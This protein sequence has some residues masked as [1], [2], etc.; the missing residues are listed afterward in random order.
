MKITKRNQLI[1]IVIMGLLILFSAYS[2]DNNGI[3]EPQDEINSISQPVGIPND[4]FQRI[5]WNAEAKSQMNQL[6]RGSHSHMIVANNGGSV[7]GSVTFDNTVE[8]PAEALGENTMVT[9][10]VIVVENHNQDGAEVDFLPS[11]EFLS[12]VVV[13]LSWSYLELADDEEFEAFYSQDDGETWFEVNAL[14]VNFE[15]ETLS[16][17]IDHFTRFAWGK[18]IIVNE[19]D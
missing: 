7:G 18:R 13:T 4:Q 15:D 19:E 10:E 3:M 14:E 17:Q 5:G 16:F 1:Q 12:D 9:V 2:C 6:A 8:I 11:M